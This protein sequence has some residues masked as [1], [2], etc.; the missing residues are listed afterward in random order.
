MI[1]D[2]Y[3]MW[4]LSKVDDGRGVCE[5]HSKL[6]DLLYSTSYEYAFELDSNRAAAGTNLRSIYAMENGLYLDDVRSGEC[7]VFEMLVALSDKLSFETQIL[8]YEWF[9]ELMS[10]LGLAN[11]DDDEYDEN[12]ILTKLYVWM[13]HE[14]AYD[15]TG[16]LFPL[17]QHDG[18]CRNMEVWD[19]M[20]AYLVE[21]FP[22]GNWM[23]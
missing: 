22:I 19:Q 6:L 23:E 14:Y 16:S 3:Y 11:Q 2:D 20:N 9:W 10:N 18:D 15:G 1:R 8:T 21:N 7:T 5:M 4:L 12:Y 13:N 17:K